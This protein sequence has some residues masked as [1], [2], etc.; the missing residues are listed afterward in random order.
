MNITYFKGW[1]LGNKVPLAFMETNQA[2]KAHD[3]GKPYTALVGD[4]H[5]P[6]CAIEVRLDREYVGVTFFDERLNPYVTYSF[7]LRESRLFLG[8]AFYIR[9]SANDE[10]LQRV[11]FRFDP[12]GR[13]EVEKTDFGADSVMK[14]D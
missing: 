3:K 10:V 8:Q 2:R 5:C 6:D 7:S 1:F 14:T 11:M 4:P 9:Y 13:M 12:N